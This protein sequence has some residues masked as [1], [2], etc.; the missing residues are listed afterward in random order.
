MLWA[1]IVTIII[2][3]MIESEAGLAERLRETKTRV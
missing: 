3:I 2:V 1:V